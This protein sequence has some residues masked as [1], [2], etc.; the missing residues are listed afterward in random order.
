MESFPMS[1]SLDAYTAPINP[2]TEAEAWYDALAKNY[3]TLA[4]AL[5]GNEHTRNGGPM[6]PPLTLMI[7]QKGP[8]L[9]WMLS[10]KQSSKTLFGT[11]CDPLDVLGSVER[12]LKAGQGE[13]IDKQPNGSGNR[14]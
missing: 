10:N 2:L 14:R 13:W 4:E 1:N 5:L 8:N 9:R 7:S 11:D 6:R 12:A 3:P